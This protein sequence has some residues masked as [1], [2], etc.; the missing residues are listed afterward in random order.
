MLPKAPLAK[1]LDCLEQIGVLTKTD[2]REWAS[3][4]V[5]VNNN[6]N[7]NNEIRTSADFSTGLNDCLETYNYPLPSP[8]DIFAK[9]SGGKVFSKLDL[10]EPYLQIS[11]DEECAK[12]LILKY[13]KKSL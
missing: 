13:T 6:N 2:Y 9:L 4:T 8:R 10:S 12:Y 7:N 5:Y 3:P 1:D 11:V